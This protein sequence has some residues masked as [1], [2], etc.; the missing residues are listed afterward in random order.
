MAPPRR[1][2]R[3]KVVST[4]ID[5]VDEEG[6]DALVVRNIAKR[7]GV[8]SGALYHHFSD[9]DDVK[10]ELLWEVTKVAGSIPRD[11]TTWQEA[12]RAHVIAFR[13]ALLSHPNIMPLL[14]GPAGH[15]TWV[16]RLYSGFGEHME[17]FL[18]LLAKDGITGPKALA[19]IEALE[20]FTIGAASVQAAMNDVPMMASAMPALKPNSRLAKVMAKGHVR[21]DD[22]FELTLRSLLDG[23]TQNLSVAAAVVE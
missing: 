11:Q 12:A 20:A 6:L 23:L 2:S 16:R 15:R 5:I 14:V 22:R 19:V 17:G 1:I 4:A 21:P 10:Q 3:E 18:A 9:M 7:L 8:Q 13:D